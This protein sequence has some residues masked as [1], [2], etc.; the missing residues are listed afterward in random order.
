[1][2]EPN[3]RSCETTTRVLRAVH[4]TSVLIAVIGLLFAGNAA[5]AARNCTLTVTSISF[6]SYLPAQAVPVNA[7][8]N[9]NVRCRGRPNG[10]QPAFYLL[11]LSAGN[12][13]SFNERYMQKSPG[14]VITYNVYI[15]A[16]HENVWGDG[17]PGTSL[18]QQTF[19][20]VG[21][22]PNCRNRYDADHPA[23]GRA[24]A[25]QDPEPGYYSDSLVVLLVF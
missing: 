2:T 23:Y 7:N 14:K 13:G 25:Y 22:G 1:M 4:G 21:N 20:C 17:S 5:W 11:G 6:G 18:I 24:E 16:L 9:V 15:D 19:P 3:N 12:S 10:G 8:G